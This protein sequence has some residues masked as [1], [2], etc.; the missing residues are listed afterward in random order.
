M[1]A[2]ENTLQ[3]GLSGQATGF[4]D[5]QG[6]AGLLRTETGGGG[7]DAVS[8]NNFT[9]AMERAHIEMA[10]ADPPQAAVEPAPLTPPAEAR[11]AQSDSASAGSQDGASGRPVDGDVVLEGLKSI[12]GAFDKQ[13][14]RAGMHDSALSVTNVNDLLAFQG[15]FHKL[16]L[17][18]D[19]TG[20]LASKP[21]QTLDMLMRG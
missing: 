14:I 13:I 20:K 7:S 5:R 4:A 3:N 12:R 17:L 19:L 21:T 10:Q 18:T 8:L 11:S 15:E 6:S 9:A 16:S 1:V 2:L